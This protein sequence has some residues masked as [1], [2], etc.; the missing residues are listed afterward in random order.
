[1]SE[2][3]RLDFPAYEAIDAVNWSRLKELAKSPAHYRYRRDNPREDTARLAF[4]RAVHTAILEPDRL[5]REY[6]VFKGTTRKGKA[7]D[8]FSFENDDKTILKADEYVTCLAVRAA[9]H[10]HGCACDLLCGESEVSATWTDAETGIPC[11]GRIDHVSTT[12]IVDLKTTS[13]VDARDFERLAARMHYFGQLA[14]YNGALGLPDP[15]KIIA[16][17]MEPPHD[18]AVFALTDEALLAGETQV[19]ELM[20][21]LA[22]CLGTDTWPGR[23]AD[24]QDLDAPSWLMPDD[25]ELGITIGGKAA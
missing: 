4:G 20:L 12:G 15:P 13:S 7:W 8:E 19:C 6:A 17:E 11:K 5:E 22:T 25:G 21:R 18:V 10:A 1:M 9:V 24:E 3:L 16:V 14:F 2:I 23:Y